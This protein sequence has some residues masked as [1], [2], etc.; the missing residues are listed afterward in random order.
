LQPKLTQIQECGATLLA[1][2]PMLKSISALLVQKLGLQFPL[3]CDTGNVVAKKFGLVYTVADSLQAVYEGFG[4]DL[5][6]ANGD[7]SH[8]LPLPA[9]YILNSDGRVAYSFVDVDHTTRLDP[10]VM[11][12]KLKTAQ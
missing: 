8:Q 3:L 6:K 11:I 7:D 10:E 2:S 1:I 12:A 9:T 5:D 4:I